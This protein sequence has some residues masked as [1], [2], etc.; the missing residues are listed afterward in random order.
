[1]GDNIETIFDLATFGEEKP[2]MHNYMVAYTYED[3][4]KQKYGSLVLT[5]KEDT[6]TMIAEELAQ[7]HSYITKEISEY[8][9]KQIIILNIVRFN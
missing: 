6:N 4:N 3:N 5:E 7:F 1:M 2:V 9:K 8:Q